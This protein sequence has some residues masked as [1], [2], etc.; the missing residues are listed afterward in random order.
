MLIEIGEQVHIATRR[1]FDEN[2]R[3]HFVG[4]VIAAEGVVVRLE[5]YSFIYDAHKNQYLK[6]HEVRTS[7]FDLAESGYIVNIIPSDIDI[8]KLAYKTV[9]REHLVITDGE[10]FSLG[11]NEF[12]V[13]R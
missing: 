8:E 11:I 7:I 1:L 4:K 2:I 9:D 5:G 13:N 3:R 12:G 6:S 10:S